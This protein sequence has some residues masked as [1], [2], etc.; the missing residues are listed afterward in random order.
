MAKHVWKFVNDP[1]SLVSR[2]YKAKYFTESHILHAKAPRDSSFIWQGIITA[3]NEIAHG[4]RWILGDGATIRCIN[5]PWL[6]SKD[7]F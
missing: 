6:V 1:Q 7:N 4:F 5:D 2:F 3:K